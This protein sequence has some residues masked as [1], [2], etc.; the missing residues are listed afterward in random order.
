MS[1]RHR[2]WEEAVDFQIGLRPIAIADWLEGGED[3][4]AVRKDALFERARD[5]VWAETEGSEA[6]QAE[7]LGLIETA[8]GPAP[9]QTGMPP[10]YV[11]SRRV[12]DDLCLMEKVEGQWRL[13]ALS[14]SAGGFFT[15]TEAI[16]KSLSELH[17]PVTGFAERFLTRVQ[18][19]F[20][21]L[22]P[23]LVLERRNWT[24]LNSGEL[25]TPSSSPIRALIPQIDPREAGRTLRLRVERQTLRRLPQTGGALFTI[26]VWLA[27]LGDLADDPQ[28]L[29]AFAHAW[30][31][32][33]PDLR[34]YKRFDLY[35][36]LVEAFLRDPQP[37]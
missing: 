28:R 10:L 6:G 32:A 4:P 36:H 5:L 24:V 20:E 3:D 26:R 1:L 9:A 23:E 14:L 8:L 15:A 31:S 37:A 25:H 22:R 19:V 13:T 2:P 30:R 34:A 7:A 21:G 33:T 35:D 18:R 11:A 12:A 27:P 16:G 29:A 17:G